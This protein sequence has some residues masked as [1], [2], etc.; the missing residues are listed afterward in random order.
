MVDGKCGTQ[1]DNLKCG[2]PWGDCCSFDG[3][4]GTGPD[5]CGKGKC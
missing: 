4:C 3:V 5:F 1:H 2:G